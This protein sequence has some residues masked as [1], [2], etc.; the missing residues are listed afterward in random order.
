MKTLEALFKD[1]LADMY[2]AENRIV[3]ALPKL[4]KAA[5]NADLKQGLESHLQETQ[6]HVEKLEQV[7][8]AFE[9]EAEA[10]KCPA[11]VGLLEEGDEI[12]SEFKGSQAINAAIISACQ[13]VEHYEIASYGT[14]SEWARMLGNDRAAG[15]LDEI[16]EEEKA[17]DEKLNEVAKAGANDEALGN[18][19]SGGTTAAGKKRRTAD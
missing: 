13:K 7:F 9:E 18:G 15:L 8:E 5:T 3:K 17:A 14:L 11:M 2:D 6:G 19:E 16:L 4:I 10:K 12:A 1:E